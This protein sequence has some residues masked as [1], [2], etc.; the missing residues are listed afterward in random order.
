MCGR[1][2]SPSALVVRRDPQEKEGPHVRAFFD[3][4]PAW[5]GDH[6]GTRAG[7]SDDAPGVEPDGAWPAARHAPLPA[8]YPTPV[9]RP[10]PMPEP[11][12]VGRW[13]RWASWLI[14]WK[15]SLLVLLVAFGIPLMV[16][17]S[18]QL[19]PYKPGV[20][21]LEA[22]VAARTVLGSPIDA[23]LPDGGSFDR[24][25]GQGPSAIATVAF[26]ATGP[27]GE[28]RVYVRARR[29]GGAWRV[30]AAV[31]VPAGAPGGIDLIADRAMET[32]DPA[33]EAA[34]RL[35]SKDW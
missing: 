5:S 30:D 32:G 35:G 18:W 20:A 23:D 19:G 6:A 4:E 13:L 28:G 7:A 29:V 31:L 3:S 21:L 24:I 22:S 14:G 17:Y 25:D 16:L 1:A 9:S 33:L 27:A 8:S 12:D 2:S 34:M 11:Y 10:A 15:Q 26:E